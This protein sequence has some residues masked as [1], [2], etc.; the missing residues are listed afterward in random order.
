MRGRQ[1]STLPIKGHLLGSECEEHLNTR[2][3]PASSSLL[4]KALLTFCSSI[5]LE[6]LF[7]G[8]SIS[9]PELAAKEA[10]FT[11]CIL[12]VLGVCCLQAFG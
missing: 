8:D 9:S 3:A 1:V 10:L 12:I 5:C 7:L 4:Q 11:A 2:Q 6:R